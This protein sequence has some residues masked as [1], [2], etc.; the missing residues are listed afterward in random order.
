LKLFGK[1]ESGPSIFS[2]KGRDS[3]YTESWQHDP[4]HLNRLHTMDV[5]KLVLT[6]LLKKKKI[7]FFFS[8]NYIFLM[9]LDCFEVLILEINFKNKNILFWYFFKVKIILKNNRYSTG[10]I[11]TV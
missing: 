8:L 11:Q 5:W 9:Y 2:F 1:V 6:C 7:E 4:Y 3:R 10:R